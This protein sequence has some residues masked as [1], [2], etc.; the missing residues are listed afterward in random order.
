MEM[1]LPWL[2]CGR[3]WWWG[4]WGRVAGSGVAD[5]GGGWLDRDLLMRLGVG[6]LVAVV[7]LARDRGGDGF[8]GSLAR[9][10]D[11]CARGRGQICGVDGRWHGRWRRRGVVL[12]DGAA[13]GGWPSSC[14]AAGAVRRWLVRVEDRGHQIVA[15]SEMAH[16]MGVAC[17][18]IAGRGERWVRSVDG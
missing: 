1:L 4:Q 2:A 18:W 15:G 10:S 8:V 11:G 6:W 3:C 5:R 17:C 12:A 13:G 14:V 9:A 7:G 16:L